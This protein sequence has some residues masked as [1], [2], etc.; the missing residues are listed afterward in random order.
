VHTAIA[1]NSAPHAL[2]KVSGMPE[3]FRDGFILV[4]H[5]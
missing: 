3:L 1:F 5:I 4:A 2:Q